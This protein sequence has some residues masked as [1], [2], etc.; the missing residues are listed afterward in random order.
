MTAPNL[1][2]ARLAELLNHHT[3]CAALVERNPESDWRDDLLQ[4]H[5]DRATALTELLESRKR[6]AADAELRRAAEAL[7][8][9][10]E[11]VDAIADRTHE[12]FIRMRAA[13]QNVR[14]ALHPPQPAPESPKPAAEAP[15][16]VGVECDACGD[17]GLGADERECR[18]C[19]PSKLWQEI[20]KLRADN[21][22]LQAE[23][24]AARAE[25]DRIA[26]GHGYLDDTLE[27]IEQ[28]LGDRMKGEHGRANGR[29]VGKLVAD[30]AKA[31]AELAQL[32]AAQAGA[33][34]ERRE[35]NALLDELEVAMMHFVRD[36]SDDANKAV[37]E[38]RRRVFNALL[39]RPPAAAVEAGRGAAAEGAK[40]KP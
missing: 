35:A 14:A 27:D 15:A 33:G 12:S 24:A 21:A 19:A 26:D 28:A 25:R 30:L 36:G 6:L 40:E 32:R 1:P 34:T 10:C 4:Y 18:D 37:T 8:P 7:L 38:V 29:I 31:E 17:S 11:Y 16:P 23:L 22:K 5:R 9:E 20:T 39:R 13:M 2:D 3:A